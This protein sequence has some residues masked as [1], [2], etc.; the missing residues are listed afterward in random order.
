M[1]EY[2]NF[3]ILRDDVQKIPL[4]VILSTNL[5]GKVVISKATG[6]LDG[7]LVSPDNSKIEC[8]VYDFSLHCPHCDVRLSHLE[9]GYNCPNC[10]AIISQW[11]RKSRTLSYNVVEKGNRVVF[12]GEVKEIQDSY[13]PLLETFEE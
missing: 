7:K 12:V 13:L 10:G 6:V 3:E 1:D 5:G 8:K 4:N 2:T 9:N 11:E